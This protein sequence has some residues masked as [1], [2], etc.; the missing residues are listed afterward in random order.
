MF[1]VITLIE[2]LFYKLNKSA[3]FVLCFVSIFARTYIIIA[4]GLLNKQV[5]K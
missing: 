5:I 4:F 1:G 3:C 2:G